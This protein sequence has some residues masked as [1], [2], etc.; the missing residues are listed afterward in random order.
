MPT[1]PTD[2]RQ[3]L[4]RH[5]QEHVLAEWD[6]L[7]EGARA[8]LLAQLQALD[9]ERLAQLYAQ[10]DK[11]IDLPAPERIS[12]VPIVRQGQDEK[13]ARS[14]GEEALRQGQVGLVLVAGGQGSRLGFHRPK[15]MFPVTPVA[16]HSLFQVHAEKALALGRRHGKPLPF[17]IMT[18]DATHD[19]TVAYFA[20][21]GHFGLAPADVAFFRQGTMPA[22]E[23]AT[24]KLLV[25]SPGRLFA[26]PNGHGG[27]LT[28]LAD[29]GLLASMRER[30]VRHLFYFQVDN[31]LVKIADPFF[32]GHHLAVDAE[33]SSKIVP[34]ETPEDRVGNLVQVDGRCAM[35][36]YSDLPKKLAEQRRPDGELLL[37]AA[38][39]AIHLFSVEF[40]ER[41]A[42][43][44]TTSLPFHVAR[45]KVPH[46]H[47]A[48]PATENALKFEMFVFDV[49][50]LAERWCVVETS[51]RE[52]FAP[53]KNKDGKD[54]PETCARAQVELAADWLAHAG[55]TL[56]R[57]PDGA[58]RYA[59]EISPLFA[60][61]KEEL[62]ARLPAGTTIAGPTFFG[63][64]R[65]EGRNR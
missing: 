29:S 16:C 4:E 13:A 61:D 10:R 52:E 38:N 9:L 5:H 3:R 55:V 21:N 15:G 1:V 33:A 40:L 43:T 17:L 49:L 35:I 22:L 19:E 64:E 20:E 23:L 54:S 53:L 12:P 37:G 6:R 7:D 18:S 65:G 30:G 46:L 58:P 31:P 32:L 36:E 14:R 60:L 41:M 39:P 48:E 28:A 62:A 50:P 56:P 44:A 34:K 2:L 27:T 51:H 45:K 24:G 11:P 47:E 59:V 63:P 25:E 8:G 42:R 26:S 57:L